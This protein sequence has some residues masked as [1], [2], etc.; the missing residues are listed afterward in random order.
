LAA[1]LAP[2]QL[3]FADGM[4]AEIITAL[5]RFNGFGAS[6]A[7]DLKVDRPVANWID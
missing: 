1:I 4:V 5:S 2:E 3:Y 6:T 7:R